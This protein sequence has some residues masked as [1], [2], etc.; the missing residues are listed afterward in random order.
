MACFRESSLQGYLEE[1]G[2]SPLR[3][4]VENSLASCARCRAAFDRVAARHRRVNSW[5][6]KLTSPAES[7]EVDAAAALARVLNRN[8]ATRMFAS[9]AAIGGRG[10]NPRAIAWS[11]VFEGAM[12]AILMVI[13]T[14]DAVR[15]KIAQ[16]TLIAPPPVVK[17]LPLKA[18]RGGG[19]GQH[20]ILPPAKGELPRPAPRVFTPPLVT[21]EHPALLMDDTTLMAPA[22]AWAAP[23]G[24]IGN[25]LA[26]VNGAGGPGNGGGLGGGH[27]IGIGDQSGPGYGNAGDAGVYT[28]GNGTTRPEVLYRVDPEYS[29]EARK[30][31]YSGAVTLSIVVNT[32]GRAEDIRVVRSLGM[33]LDEKAVEAVE[34]WRFRPGT[35]KG[36]AVRVRAQI[37]V[38]FRLL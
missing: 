22:D 24:N 10:T 15:T 18:N 8:Q 29:E 17:T 38:S 9:G 37:L 23:A 16:T 11:L 31:K 13:G 25:P 14:S 21:V 30:A 33:G 5:L 28:V 1:S 4:A 3:E 27:E 6:A 26:G 19:G 20:S 2:A 12:V 7:V 34:K 32:D 35:N 36:V